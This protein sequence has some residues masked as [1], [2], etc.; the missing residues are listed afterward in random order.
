VPVRST[1]GSLISALCFVIIHVILFRFALAYYLLKLQSEEKKQATARKITNIM[2]WH[3]GTYCVNIV[4]LICLDYANDRRLE[5]EYF[6]SCLRLKM[7]N[8]SPFEMQANR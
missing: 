5:S 1:L 7:E 8:D 2:Y 6:T 3:L 4:S